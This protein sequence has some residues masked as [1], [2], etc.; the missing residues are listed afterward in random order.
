MFVEDLLTHIRFDSEAEKS[1]KVT[2]SFYAAG[3]RHVETLTYGMLE[4]DKYGNLNINV[5]FN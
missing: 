1:G 5:E 4:V 2:V 3:G